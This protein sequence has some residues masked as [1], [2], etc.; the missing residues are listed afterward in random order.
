MPKRVKNC[1][2]EERST[3]IVMFAIL[4]AGIT[5][6]DLLFEN[7][8]KTKDHNWQ[9]EAVVGSGAVSI[10]AFLVAFFCQMLLHIYEP[11]Q[12]T[13]QTNRGRECRFYTKLTSKEIITGLIC[14]GIGIAAEAILE[15]TL[16]HET[17]D[18]F[19]SVLYSSIF[20]VSKT[21]TRFGGV[22]FFEKFAKCKEKLTYAPVSQTINDTSFKA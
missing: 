22:Y 20:S 6:I 13:R 4:F 8:W 10:Y 5:G 11:H 12:T 21:A 18:S 3:E 9:E 2:A 19:G 7:L 14:F 15:A 16:S 17:L 1:F